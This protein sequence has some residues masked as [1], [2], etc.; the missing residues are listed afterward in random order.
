MPGKTVCQISLFDDVAAIVTHRKDKSVDELFMK[1][2]RWYIQR[3]VAAC[4]EIMAACLFMQRR[5]LFLFRVRGVPLSVFFTVPSTAA[6]WSTLKGSL[7]QPGKE[8]LLPKCFPEQIK[9][10][11]CLLLHFLRLF[12]ELG[13]LVISPR[14]MEKRELLSDLGTAHSSLFFML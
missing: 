5:F 10:A 11:L 4:Q 8:I 1:C 3:C 2:F 14:V 13:Q 12:K 6:I 9:T 7:P